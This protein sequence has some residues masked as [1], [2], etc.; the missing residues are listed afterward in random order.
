MQLIRGGAPPPLIPDQHLP[1]IESSLLY[2]AAAVAL[3][4]GGAGAF[5]VTRMFV[6][7]PSD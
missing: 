7:R 4:V 2:L 1:R 6:P 5:S 3:F